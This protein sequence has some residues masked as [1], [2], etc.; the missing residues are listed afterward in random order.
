MKIVSQF[1]YLVDGLQLVPGVPVEVEKGKA[2]Q[3]LALPGVTK[4]SGEL[5][6]SEA[7]APPPALSDKE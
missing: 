3:L 1:N 4:A 6:V 5:L 2:A 7:P